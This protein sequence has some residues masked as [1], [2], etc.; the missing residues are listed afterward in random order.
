MVSVVKGSTKV[1]DSNSLK[2][3]FEHSCMLAESHLIEVI[4]IVY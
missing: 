4:L 2:F 3:S 1:T